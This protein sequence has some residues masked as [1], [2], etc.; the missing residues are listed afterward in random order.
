MIALSVAKLK[1]S[2]GKRNF[3]LNKDKGEKNKTFFGKFGS[4]PTFRNDV[5]KEQLTYDIPFT[6]KLEPNKLTCF[7]LFVFAAQMV[8]ALHRHCRGHEFESC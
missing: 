1:I 8:R 2:A 6:G 4:M 7:Q 5:M 3:S